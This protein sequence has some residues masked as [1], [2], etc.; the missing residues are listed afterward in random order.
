MTVLS[1]SKNAALRPTAGQSS[2]MVY[3][4]RGRG[5]Q[6]LRRRYVGWDAEPR[7]A[8]HVMVSESHRR[9]V[10]VTANSTRRTPVDSGMLGCDTVSFP[11]SVVSTLGGCTPRDR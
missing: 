3:R 5:S 9:V 11:S 2:P 10:H 6:R 4:R 7:P 8:K 1:R